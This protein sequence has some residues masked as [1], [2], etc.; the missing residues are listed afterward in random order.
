MAAR[1]TQYC[2]KEML[3]S[4]EPYCAP[5]PSAASVVR[6]CVPACAPWTGLYGWASGRKARCA[7]FRR[8]RKFCCEGGPQPAIHEQVNYQRVHAHMRC[9]SSGCSPSGCGLGG[10]R[11]AALGK[12]GRMCVQSTGAA[13]LLSGPPTLR[14]RSQPP[15]MCF[16]SMEPT[17]HGRTQP[18]L[19][20]SWHLAPPPH[21]SAA[22]SLRRQKGSHRGSRCRPGA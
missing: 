7:A 22:P 12:C 18:S 1:G 17:I 8:R 19:R 15:D 4:L 10:G 16:P 6:A 2:L 9:C 11:A 3:G 20:L 13:C 14:S 21:R 5:A